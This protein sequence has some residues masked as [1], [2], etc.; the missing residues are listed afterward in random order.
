VV[1]L[2]DSW[3]PLLPNGHLLLCFSASS[4]LASKRCSKI[5]VKGFSCSEIFLGFFVKRKMWLEKFQRA[6]EA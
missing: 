4:V 6:R 2:A 5:F 3:G 1:P